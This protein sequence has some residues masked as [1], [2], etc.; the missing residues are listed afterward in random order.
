MNTPLL[1]TNSCLPCILGLMGGYGEAG[2]VRLP[3]LQNLNG[4]AR[5]RLCCC[6]EGKHPSHMESEA[7]CGSGGYPSRLHP[8]GRQPGF[9]LIGQ[10]PQGPHRRTVGLAANYPPLYGATLAVVAEMVP[11]FPRFELR[12]TVRRGLGTS[13]LCGRMIGCHC[14]SQ[15]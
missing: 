10:S 4:S 8:N 14:C 12:Q 9:R 1:H 13:F 6:G 11:D 15:N 3:L 2:L 7:G 5:H